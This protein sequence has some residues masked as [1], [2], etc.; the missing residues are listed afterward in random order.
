M[1]YVLSDVLAFMPFAFTMP[2]DF[3]HQSTESMRY[4][5]TFNAPSLV[6][7]AVVSSYFYH[8]RILMVRLYIVNWVFC[9]F[10]RRSS[11]FIHSPKLDSLSYFGGTIV[12]R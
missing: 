2:I 1:N 6:R 4:L 7:V 8:Q 12:G 9:A 3:L 11:V 10:I 5:A